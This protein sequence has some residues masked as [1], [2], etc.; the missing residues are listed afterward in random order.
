MTEQ[1]IRALHRKDRQQGNAALFDTY[2]SYVCAVVFRR[3]LSCGT[4]EDAEECVIDVFHEVIRSFDSIREGGLHSYIAACAHNHAVNLCRS[5]N[6]RARHSTSADLTECD[7]GEDIPDNAEDAEQAR[8]LL[9]CIRELGEPDATILIQKYYLG[10]N[11]V[12]IASVIG[13]N[14]VTVR[15]RCARALKRLRILLEERG[16]TL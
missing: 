7:S 4:R 16:V 2:Y 13:K 10:A 9:E 3:V 5:L 1:E 12:R 6:A 15:S 11:S 8:I 14:P